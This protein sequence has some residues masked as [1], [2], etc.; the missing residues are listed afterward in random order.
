MSA[1]ARRAPCA[2]LGLLAA[3]CAAVPCAAAWREDFSPG[4]LDPLRWRVTRAGD[5]RTHVAE[6][7]PAQRGPGFRLRLATDT[8][9]TRDDS[10]KHVG[11]ASR[12]AIALGRDARVRVLLDWGPPA[13]GSY[14]AGAVVLSPHATTGDPRATA[15]WLSVGY[16]GVPPGRN[17][18]LLVAARVNGV[19]R[20]LFEEGWPGANREGR[21]VGRSELEVAWRGSSLE[22]RE[23]GRLVHTASAADAS[24]ESAH[25]YLQL[26]SHSNF[27]ARAIH[28]EDLRITQGGDDGPARSF[29]AAPECEAGLAR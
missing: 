17:A 21:P 13:N 3:L 16:V 5:S 2:C 23:G 14:L 6:V 12:C 20:T 1:G 7:V 26:S 22:F 4:S 10:V 8:R 27:P 19:S 24:F 25:V 11:V 29:P 28:F 15:D 9:G 18:R